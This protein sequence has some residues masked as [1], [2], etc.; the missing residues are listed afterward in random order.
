MM[1]DFDLYLQLRKIQAI[2]FD[3]ARAEVHDPRKDLDWLEDRK[4]ESI[5]G[6]CNITKQGVFL[7]MY[8]GIPGKLW[9]P[10]G[11]WGCWGSGSG[12]S[13]WLQ[14][15]LS[16][17]GAT[18]HLPETINSWGVFG[19]VYAIHSVDGVPLPEPELLHGYDNDGY[20]ERTA[21]WNAMAIKNQDYVWGVPELEHLKTPRYMKAREQWE[22]GIT[23]FRWTLNP[24]YLLNDDL[25]VGADDSKICDILGITLK[26]LAERVHSLD[27]AS[28]FREDGSVNSPGP[29]EIYPQFYNLETGIRIVQ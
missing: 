14:N 8:Y 23:A 19:P 7:E 3:Y 5:R 1:N 29:L 26:E 6:F 28:F 18:L 20:N 11:S 13:E 21:A 25:Y 22:K 27:V 2:P 4:G 12:N 24:R 10:W 16:R 15:M 9:T 17:L